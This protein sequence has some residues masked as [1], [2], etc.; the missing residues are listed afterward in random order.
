M[1]NIQSIC[2][3]CGSSNGKRPD[4]ATAAGALGTELARRGIRLVYG[5]GDVGTMG[6]LARAALAR[7]PIVP[8][9]PPP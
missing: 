1:T 9:S 5:G 3:F 6:I 7:M 8:T 4:F 2:V